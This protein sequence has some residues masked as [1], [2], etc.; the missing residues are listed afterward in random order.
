MVNSTASAGAFTAIISVVQTELN[1]RAPGL[2]VM[3]IDELLG[4]G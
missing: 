3:D 1:K 2:R 4:F